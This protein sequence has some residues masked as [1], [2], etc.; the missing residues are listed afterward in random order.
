MKRLRIVLTCLFLTLLAAVVA[1]QRPTSCRVSLCLIDSESNETLPG[2]VRVLDADGTPVPVRRIVDGDGAETSL[3]SRG[4][5]VKDQPQLEQWFVVTGEVTLLMP[6]KA[7]LVEAFSGL[8]TELTRQKIDLTGRAELAVRVPLRSFYDSVAKRMRSANTHLHLMKLTREQADRYLTEIPQADRLDALFVSHLER[9]GAD[10]DYISNT[11]SKADLEQ[12]QQ[13]SGTV[14]GNGEEHRHNFTAQGEGYGHVM[15][16]D[17]AQLVQPV[18]LGPGITKTGT[19][20]TPVQRGIDQARRA[21]ATAI[22]C[23]NTLGMERVAN[24]V[25]GRLNAQNIFD[26]GARGSFKDSFYLALNAGFKVPFSTGT[27]WFIYDFSRTYV[28]VDGPLT[29]KSWL[30]GL[31]AGRSYITNGPLLEFT[32][33]GI[34]PGDRAMLARSGSVNV[35]AR[36]VGRVDFRRLELVQNGRVVRTKETRAAAEGGHFVAEMRLDLLV[37]QPC[38]FALRVPPPPVKDDPELTE[39]VPLNEYGQ[40]LFAHTSAVDVEV[41]GIRYV[42]RA[43]LQTLLRTLRENVRSMNA[44]AQFGDEGEKARVNDVYHEAITELEKRLTGLN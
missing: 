35:T 8:E 12:L 2:V 40:P 16:L 42:E 18:S 23:H 41:G 25:T 22:W 32:V 30:K 31:A 39:P 6:P 34:E 9:A 33:D 13:V 3:L 44:Q 20:G 43:A 15:L 7:I 21:D 26:G 19:D 5:G 38:W 1:A 28:K 11:Y 4:L 14:F 17:L 10:Q 37:D 27:D 24:L 36:G 29:V